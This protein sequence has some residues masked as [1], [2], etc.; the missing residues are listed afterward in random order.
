MNSTRKDFRDPNLKYRW[1]WPI[2]RNFVFSEA[3]TSECT[4]TLE[5]YGVVSNNR[6]DRQGFK[7]FMNTSQFVYNQCNYFIADPGCKYKVI[8][9]RDPMSLEDP[10][11]QLDW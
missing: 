9:L 6:F 2:T 3:V 10:D 7:E 4:E 5:G 11:L 8:E 1:T